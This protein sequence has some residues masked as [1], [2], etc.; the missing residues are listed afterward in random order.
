MAAVSSRRIDAG[1]GTPELQW[2]RWLQARALP[3]LAPQAL[4]PSGARAV[5]VAPHPDDE[6]LAVGGLLAHAAALGRS[7]LVVAVT[8]GEASHAGSPH[9]PPRR[10]ATRRRAETRLALARLGSNAAV[11]RAGLADGRVAAQAD[12]LHA[13][14]LRTLR[15]SDRV[16]TTWALD[17]HPDHEATG[18]TARAA[19]AQVGARIYE[20]P[21][22]GW[23]WAQC[24]DA[25][26]P[27]AQAHLVALSPQAV[28][29]KSAAL[30]AFASQWE[31][32]PACPHTPILRASMRARAQR[33][34]EVVFA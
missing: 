34:F 12:V 23:H 13:L 15:P 7:A 27:W 6:V 10:L 26:M 29:R 28:A 18:R 9:W 32:D 21:V 24:G 20:V 17:G 33:P 30:Q 4:L 11:L 14:L 8:D 1:D 16:F 2:Q 22:W 5:V 31:H 19:A 3:H 25:R